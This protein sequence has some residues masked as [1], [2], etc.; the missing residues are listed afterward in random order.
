VRSAICFPDRII[1]A[2]ISRNN[3]S[4]DVLTIPQIPDLSTTYFVRLQLTDSV[5]DLVSN[6]LYWYSTQPDVLSN[7]IQWYMRAVTTYAN[8][9]GLN[10]LATNNDVTAAAFRQVEDG[11]PAH[12]RVKG[13]NVPEFTNVVNFFAGFFPPLTNLPDLNV[14]KAGTTISV[15]FSLDGDKGL[16]ILAEGYPKSQAISCSSTALVDG[17]E[18]A[19]PT[20]GS[21]LSYNPATDQYTYNWKTN[22]AWAGTCRQLVVKLMDGAYHQVNFQ[23][24]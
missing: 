17:V 6:N 5:G 4:T 11:Q 3:I 23:F 1:W 24:R 16:E 9:K 21:G 13:Y 8:L 10:D 15:K 7:N 14:A 12:I 20:G 22:K 18:R 19:L 2:N